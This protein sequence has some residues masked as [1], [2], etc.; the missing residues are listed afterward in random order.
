MCRFPTARPVGVEVGSRSAGGLLQVGWY[1]TGV[2][3]AL[4]GC[5]AAGHGGGRSHAGADVAGLGRERR[6][7]GLAGIVLKGG[8]V[9][10]LEGGAGG[11]STSG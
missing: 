8:G 5:L 1:R 3:T 2:A 4:G 10:R 6:V 9:R 11:G 7:A